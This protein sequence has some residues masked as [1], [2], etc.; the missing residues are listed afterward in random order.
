M[1]WTMG[2]T[3]PEIFTTWPFEK[4]LANLELKDAPACVGSFE[5][6]RELYAWLNSKGWRW[7]LDS[8]HAVGISPQ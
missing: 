2:P 1:T 3:K 4:V 8:L 7:R 6:P 5:M